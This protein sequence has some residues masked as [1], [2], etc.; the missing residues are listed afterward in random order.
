MRRGWFQIL[1]SMVAALA[2]TMVLAGCPPKPTEGGPDPTAQNSPVTDADVDVVETGGDDS[3]GMEAEGDGGGMM[4]APAEAQ[5]IQADIDSYKEELA[6]AGS[7]MCC[8]SPS[9]DMC[10]THMGGCPCGANAA[11]DK[12]VCAECKGKWHAGMGTVDGK[13][14]DDIQVMKPM[15]DMAE[16]EMDH[17]DM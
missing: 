10:A 13:S 7:Y 15:G 8:V 1:T 16:G 9:C 17:G 11:A 12:P 3:A 2:V 4:E 6:S 14:A 5:T